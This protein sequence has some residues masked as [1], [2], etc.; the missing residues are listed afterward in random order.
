[1]DEKNKDNSNIALISALLLG[2]AFLC[3]LKKAPREPRSGAALSLDTVD[4][5]DDDDEDAFGGITTR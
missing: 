1:M 2:F 4:T 3:A 5:V